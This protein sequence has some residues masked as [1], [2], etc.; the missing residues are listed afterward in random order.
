[1]K[2]RIKEINY[3]IFLESQ[4]IKLSR[5]RIKA[6]QIERANLEGQKKLEKGKVKVK[7]K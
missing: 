3:E 6:L 5:K 2:D 7:R 1:M 4:S